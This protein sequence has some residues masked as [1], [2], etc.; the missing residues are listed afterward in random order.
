MHEYAGRILHDDRMRELH[1]EAAD[2]RLVALP[3]PQ[4]RTMRG[5]AVA[6]LEEARVSASSWLRG[7]SMAHG[8]RGR[9]RPSTD[10]KLAQ[11]A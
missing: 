11:D 7:D 2:S 1:R 4:R 10:A 8:H 9:L 6:V 5:R 3:R